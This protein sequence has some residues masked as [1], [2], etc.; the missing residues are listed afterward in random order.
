ML[1]SYKERFRKN[2]KLRA[3]FTQLSPVKKFPIT[4]YLIQAVNPYLQF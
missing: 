3:D 4:N 1:N 2:G